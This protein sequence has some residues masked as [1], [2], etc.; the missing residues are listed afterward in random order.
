MFLAQ[1]A[2]NDG[3]INKI[4]NLGKRTH[5]YFSFFGFLLLCFFFPF[6][7][8]EKKFKMDYLAMDDIWVCNEESCIC[9]FLKAARRNV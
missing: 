5:F 4:R 1:T 3:T 8:R 9:H 7:F 2:R 6:A